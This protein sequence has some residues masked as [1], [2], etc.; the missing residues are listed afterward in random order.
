[1]SPTDSLF[2]FHFQFELCPLKY[3]TEHIVYTYMVKYVFLILVS[4]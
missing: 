1:L 3:L 2:A 4:P